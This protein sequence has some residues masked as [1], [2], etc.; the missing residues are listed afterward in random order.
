MSDNTYS[1]A[2]SAHWR[3]FC[4]PANIHKEV[5][6]NTVL[7]GI[8]KSDFHYCVLF[9]R[10]YEQCALDP[11]SRIS[12][13]YLFSHA[14]E[15]KPCWKA[16]YTIFFCIGFCEDTI[17][18]WADHPLLENMSVVLDVPLAATLCRWFK[19]FSYSLGFGFCSSWINYHLDVNVIRR[20][21]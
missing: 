12:T 4:C 9:N 13:D 2:F 5:N 19:Q 8:V 3:R 17:M 11:T 18:D 21:M 1:S 15:R 6:T 10:S 7:L 14:S 20:L 16:S